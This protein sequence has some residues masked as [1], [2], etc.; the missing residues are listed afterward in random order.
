MLDP[1]S[2][3]SFKEL[4][5]LTHSRHL[6]PIGDKRYKKNWIDILLLDDFFSGINTG[7]ETDIGVNPFSTPS[8]ELEL[9]INS[10][11]QLIEN[12]NP[13]QKEVID[14]CFAN[15]ID[16]DGVDNYW[17][18]ELTDALAAKDADELQRIY[19]NARSWRDTYKTPE[20]AHCRK[21]WELSNEEQAEVFKNLQGYF[22][23]LG[24]CP[25]PLDP[26]IIKTLAE[27]FS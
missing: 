9:N 20:K 5:K 25:D 19:D 2:H 27:E 22:Q 18:N 4:K 7:V 16:T 11:P 17:W 3:L 13:A 6:V 12:S 15:H 10:E 21:L 23:A 24:N 1:Y 8:I 14:I 26:D